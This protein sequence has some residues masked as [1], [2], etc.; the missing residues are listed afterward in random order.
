MEKTEKLNM[1]EEMLDLDEGALKETQQ[2]N[3]LEEWDSIARLSLIILLEDEFGKQ[4]SGA[5]IKALETVAE[6]L[7]LME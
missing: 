7:A 5:E 3:E 1:L 4:L 6:I 2:L